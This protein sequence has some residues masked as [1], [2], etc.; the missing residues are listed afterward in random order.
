MSRIV[1][2]DRYHI[3]T[4]GAMMPRQNDIAADDENN[5]IGCLGP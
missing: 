2:E 4:P 1:T 3:S 5:A